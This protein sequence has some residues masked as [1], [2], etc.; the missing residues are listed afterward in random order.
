MRQRQKEAGR[1]NTVALG[2]EVE[3]LTGCLGCEVVT[4]VTLLALGISVI[5][6]TVRVGLQCPGEISSGGVEW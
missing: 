3:T 6:S 5:V 4:N 2:R 1:C